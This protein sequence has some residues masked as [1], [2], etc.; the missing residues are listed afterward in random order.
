MGLEGFLTEMKKKRKV[1]FKAMLY[2][3][4]L[5]LFVRFYLIDEIRNFAKGSTTLSSLT[6]KVDF[7]EAPFITLCFLPRFK[8]S[9]LQ[10]YGLP[11]SKEVDFFAIT[12]ASGGLNTWKLF[13]KLGFAYGK[14][15][16]I[17]LQ[18]K[19][20]WEPHKD[21]KF[22]IQNVATLR[23]GLCYL[24]R[25]DANVSIDNE[26]IRL[27][28]R[29]TGLNKEVPKSVKLFLSSPNNWH[30]LIAD[31]WPLIHPL[32]FEIPL[33]KQI[34][35]R[36]IAKVSQTDYHYLSGT[37]DFEKCFIDQIEKYS[38]CP[39]KCFPSVYN[40]LPNFPPC[41]NSEDFN[42]MQNLILGFRKLRYECL[43]PKDDVQYKANIY[44]AYKTQSIGSDFF[45][46]FYFDRGTKDIK[47]EILIVTAGNFI[48]SVGGSLGLFL[49][50]SF[51][52]YM[53][54]IFD[55]ILP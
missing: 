26:R 32:M 21:I 54:G 24:I 27:Y 8:A 17:I 6:K 28:F 55:K 50:F 48:G 19:I 29:F 4:L 10:D 40:F 13:Q 14:D 3:I 39:T 30:G 9:V 23:H 15:F 33:R 2:F 52:S 47:E 16:N 42:C 46:M 37:Q 5:I 41:N 12:N 11:S 43:Y 20:E 1:I 25:Y 18:S 35:S 49:G 45:F 31:D 51:F 36:W 44:P 7:L 38:Y 53:S 22:E 34:E